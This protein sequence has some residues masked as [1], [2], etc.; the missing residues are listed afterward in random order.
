MKTIRSCSH[1]NALLPDDAP[2]GLC[3]QCLMQGVLAPGE[4]L[5]YFGN[6]ELLDEI[7]QGGMGVVWR[8]KQASLNR[9]V[10]LKMIRGGMLAT[11]DDVKRFLAEAEAA[12][13]LKHPNIVAIHEV[14]EHGGQHYFSMDFVDGK[15]L[16]DFCGGKPLAARQAAELLATIA[17]AVQFAHQR[18]ILHRDL[19]PHNVLMDAAG[20]P[21]LTDFGLAKRMDMESSLTQTGAVMGSPSYMAPEQAQA[22]HEHVGTQTD[23]YALGAILYEMLTGR[24]PFREATAAETMMRVIHAE[25]VAPSKI[26]A[27]VPRDLATICMKCLEKEPSRRYATAREVAEEAWRFLKGEPILARPAGVLRKAVSWAQR[28]PATIAG[29]I[30]LVVLGLIGFAYYLAQENAFLRAQAANP[31]LV[32]ESG[33]YAHA[34]V[35][36]NIFMLPVLLGAVWTG[37]W[38][39]KTARRLAW[40]DLWQPGRLFM[41]M[42][43]VGTNVRTASVLVGVLGLLLCLGFTGAVIKWQVWEGARLSPNSRGSTSAL[44]HYTIIF[45][46]LWMSVWLLVL[47][48]RD[49][50]LATRGLHI[51]R[52][53]PAVEKG[54]R[55]ALEDKDFLLAIQLYRQAVPEANRAEAADYAMRIAAT[56]RERDPVK[57]EDGFDGPRAINWPRL[58]LTTAIG[59]VVCV[60]VWLIIRPEHPG[61]VIYSAAFGLAFSGAIIFT[62]R[63][64]GFATRV[65]PIAAI[66]IAFQ[67]GGLI[68]FD[69]DKKANDHLIEFMLGV[70]FGL[71][72]LLSVQ[73]RTSRAEK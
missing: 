45:S 70:T 49:Y 47:S 15:N 26:N 50:R 30:A 11:P 32:R 23:V 16:A 35:M 71:S 33:T 55:A 19:K 18:G 5:Q 59:I 3:P 73:T 61:Q 36:W 64:K 4:R 72:M 51:R 17:D 48:W 69:G 22:R 8:A 43:Q 27:D 28:H 12:A 1:C 57:F 58:L 60:A 9:T 63:A 67:A 29:V 20:T 56:L 13:N 54:L 65:L 24:A 21:H 10:A 37:L 14:G 40:R 7:A 38:F 6:Y 68:W 42:Q 39:S 53:E 41:P 34:V 66:M 52:L 46:G 62:R 25:P 31:G 2:G 44:A